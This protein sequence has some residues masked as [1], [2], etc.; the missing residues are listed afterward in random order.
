M[1]STHNPI[2]H[3]AK[4]SVA[5]FAACVAAAAGLATYGLSSAGAAT[6]KGG[7]EPTARRDRSDLSYSLRR[8]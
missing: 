2:R 7:P 1:S 3:V 8:S 4:R 5:M 6:A